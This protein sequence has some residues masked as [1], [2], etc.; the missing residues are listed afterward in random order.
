MTVTKGDSLY[1]AGKVASENLNWRSTE[2]KEG[3]VGR[4]VDAIQD[5]SARGLTAWHVVRDFSM[6]RISPLRLRSRPLLWHIGRDE[7]TK[8]TIEGKS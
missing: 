2:K 1:F 6:R 4:V 3:S 5:L 7:A 8:D